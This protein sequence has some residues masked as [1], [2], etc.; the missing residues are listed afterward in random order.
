MFVTSHLLMPHISNCKVPIVERI[1]HKTRHALCV[2]GI[3]YCVQEL[4]V[5]LLEDVLENFP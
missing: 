1:P 3:L 5:R 2:D 4:E